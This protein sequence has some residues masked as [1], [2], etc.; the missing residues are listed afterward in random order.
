MAIK[1]AK[2]TK[3]NI[4]IKLFEIF[5]KKELIS[6]Q[7]YLMANIG[8]HVFFFKDNIFKQSDSKVL[9]E[10]LFQIFNINCAIS[11]YSYFKFIFL[12]E[13]NLVLFLTICFFL[14]MFYFNNNTKNFSKFSIFL[15]SQFYKLVFLAD[16]KSLKNLNP[17]F[18]FDLILIYLLFN[19][20][21]SL[22]L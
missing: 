13:S 4:A 11:K 18:G 5:L 16:H 20:I 17:N 9:V 19:Q 2:L 7:I 1:K 6:F 21:L 3:K 10:I 14:E 22:D 8:Y 12:P 15:K